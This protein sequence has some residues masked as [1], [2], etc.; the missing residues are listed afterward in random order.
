MSALISMIPLYLVG[1][2]HC[3]GMCGP[4]VAFLGRHPYKYAY[5][6]GRIAGFTLAGLIAGEMGI[7][8]ADVA[9]IG[10]FSAILTLVISL[11]FFIVSLFFFFN[12]KIPLFKS[13]IFTILERLSL[14]ISKLALSDKWLSVFLFGLCTILLPCGQSLII[15]S[16]SAMLQDSFL[17][18][19]NGF[20]FAVFTTPSL[21]FTMKASIFLT[22]AKRHYRK[23]MSISLFIVSILTFL[24]GLADLGIINHFTL[25]DKLHLILW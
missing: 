6:W 15:F 25:I 7:I 9:S 18:A 5:F 13:K 2:F 22:K 21:M 4:L 10:K 12:I 3:A 20:L 24:R 8:V 11:I 16:F 23:L 17:G 19:L 14:T 1:N